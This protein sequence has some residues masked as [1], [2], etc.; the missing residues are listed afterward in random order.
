MGRLLGGG[1][2]ARFFFET[3][4]MDG[5]VGGIER[6]GLYFA[7]AAGGIQAGAMSVLAFMC[8]IETFGK[9]FFTDPA[10]ARVEPHKLW[11][12]KDCGRGVRC[13]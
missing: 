4:T 12:S 5:M 7:G 9:G 13:F 1:G 8:R 3:I 6:L 11:L 10:A 2:G